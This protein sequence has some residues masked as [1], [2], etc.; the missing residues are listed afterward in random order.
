[1]IS[2]VKLY[3]PPLAKAIKALEKISIEIPEVCIM[4]T[5]I[6]LMYS[7]PSPGAMGSTMDSSM[8]QDYGDVGLNLESVKGRMRY[9]GETGEI[10]E[11]RC[12]SIISKSGRSL[13]EYDF[14]FEWFK[15]PSIEQLEELISSID[16]ALKPIGVRYSISTK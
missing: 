16:K 14:Y 4:N 10:S 2:Y 11:E 3:G 1:M 15:K 9:F 12:E 6:N 13:G 7:A 8:G 5:Y